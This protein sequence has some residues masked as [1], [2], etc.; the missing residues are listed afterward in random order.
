MTSAG[1]KRKA[2][3]PRSLPI[4]AYESLEQLAQTWKGKAREQDLLPLLKQGYVVVKKV[5]PVTDI[6]KW[7]KETEQ[8]VSILDGC[9]AAHKKEENKAK[10]ESKNKDR[11]P[12]ETESD[13]EWGLFRRHWALFFFPSEW[14]TS[15][16]LRVSC[17]AW[18]CMAF[19]KTPSL[20]T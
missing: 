5:I 6:A 9:T 18:A 20:V 19:S 10:K 8:V 13:E 1:T 3:A 11:D 12:D 16:R 4:A 15:Q 7:K 14:R 17:P 2:R